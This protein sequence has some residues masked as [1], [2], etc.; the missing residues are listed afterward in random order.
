MDR[1]NDAWTE[2]SKKNNVALQGSNLTF[3]T[4]C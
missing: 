3:L 1:Y 4:T 2:D